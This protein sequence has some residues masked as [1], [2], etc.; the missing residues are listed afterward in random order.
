MAQHTTID[1]IGELKSVPEL[2]KYL[3]VSTNL[4]NL[5]KNRHSF[6]HSNI[7]SWSSIFNPIKK[8]KIRWM[9]LLDAIDT[10]FNQNS[11]QSFS[12]S[13]VAFTNTEK[14]HSLNTN[15]GIT[16]NIT[17]TIDISE[18]KLL[19]YRGFYGIKS[20][21]TGHDLLFNQTP[22]TE[23]IKNIQNKTTHELLYTQKINDKNILLFSGRY[24]FQKAPEQYFSQR[25]CIGHPIYT[26]HQNVSQN[27]TIRE[28][29]IN[30]LKKTKRNIIMN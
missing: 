14:H 2:E 1:E 7:L 6:S 5:P 27:Q 26:L 17:T 22:L 12:A 3:Q 29:E 15:R 30:W 4:P 16:T 13:N 23:N 25:A 10:N 20:S 19:T 21:K 8:V 11:V 9:N 28:L 24:T 18:K